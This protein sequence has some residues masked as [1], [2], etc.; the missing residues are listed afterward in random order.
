MTYAELFQAWINGRRG[1]QNV[2]PDPVVEAPRPQPKVCTVCGHLH[3]VQKSGENKFIEYDTRCMYCGCIANGAD[4]DGTKPG[5]IVVR[6]TCE[7]HGISGP[8]AAGRFPR[9]GH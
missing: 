5:K 6:Q 9:R 2:A 4:Y 1:N 8:C 3:R 7:L